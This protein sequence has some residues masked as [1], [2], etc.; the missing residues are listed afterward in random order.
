MKHVL[1]FTGINAAAATG[2][3]MILPAAM[4][5][6]TGIMLGIGVQGPNDA[7]DRALA[8]SAVARFLIHPAVIMEGPALA[9]LLNLV[10]VVGVKAGKEDGGY[11]ATVFVRRRPVNLAVALCGAGLLCMLVLYLIGENFAITPR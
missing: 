6:F 4:L 8:A 10:G 5:C 11:A 9:V 1:A 3:A 2:G 7:L